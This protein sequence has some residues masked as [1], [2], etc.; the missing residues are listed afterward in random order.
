[1]CVCLLTIN[2]FDRLCP[3]SV[4]FICRQPLNQQQTARYDKCDVGWGGR[5]G[6]QKRKERKRNEKIFPR[7]LLLI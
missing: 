6:N 7:C 2:S 4:L 3:Q 1:M 5:A